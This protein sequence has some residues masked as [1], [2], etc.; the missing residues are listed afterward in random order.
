L[1]PEIVENQFPVLPQGASDL[2]HGLDAGTHRL[3][4]PLVQE[5]AC[6]RGRA[7]IPELLKCFLER[8]SPDGLQVVAE[9]IA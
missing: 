6:P 9:E 4:T 5:F 8:V 2:L 3:A 1:R 7:V